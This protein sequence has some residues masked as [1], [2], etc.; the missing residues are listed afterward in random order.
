MARSMGINR[1]AATVRHPQ[2]LPREHSIIDWL[3]GWCLTAIAFSVSLDGL[4]QAA[5]TSR[6][7][8]FYLSAIAVGLASLRLI[9][10][11]N[12]TLQ[13]TSFLLLLLV[14]LWSFVLYFVNPTGGA[15][16]IFLLVQL[17]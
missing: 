16:T 4:L 1:P 12:R 7:L 8:A 10:V 2:L 14:Y 3:L 9:P 15:S 17:L 11:L 6:S 5:G 13:V